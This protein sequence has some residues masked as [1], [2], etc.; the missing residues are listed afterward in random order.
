MSWRTGHSRESM[1]AIRHRPLLTF[2]IVSAISVLFPTE[3][4][5]DATNLRFVAVAGVIILVPR[6]LFTVFVEG[7]VLTIGLRIPYRRTLAV[8]LAATLASLAAGIPVTISNIAV[9]WR[10]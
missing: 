4:R 2:T 1:E 7:I 10:P 9:A 5:A 6:T 8:L 3:A